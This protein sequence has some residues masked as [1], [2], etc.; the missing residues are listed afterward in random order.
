MAERAVGNYVKKILSCVFS[1]A[2]IDMVVGFCVEGLWKN[3]KNGKMYHFLS[4]S[5]YG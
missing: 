3:E 1:G 2:L 5:G 4:F